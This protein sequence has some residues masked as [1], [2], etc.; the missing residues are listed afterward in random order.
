MLAPTA[1]T[2]LE[3]ATFRLQIRLTI[4][5]QEIKTKVNAGVI[6][7]IQFVAYWFACRSV[8]KTS[9]CLHDSSEIAEPFFAACIL[10]TL[11]DKFCWHT[12][13][14]TLFEEPEMYLANF[15]SN[16]YRQLLKWYFTEISFPHTFFPLSTCI[17]QSLNCLLFINTSDIVQWLF[18]IM[19]NVSFEMPIYLTRFQY[20]IKI[21]TL[22]VHYN[23]HKKNPG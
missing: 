9:F 3:T 2:S 4:W 19:K 18:N 16:T 8:G 20:K 12:V 7:R 5:R 11:W 10:V 23:R 6:T 15:T 13:K 21:S 1:C 17:Y 14:R 22:I